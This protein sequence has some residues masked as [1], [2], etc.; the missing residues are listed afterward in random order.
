MARGRTRAR[1]RSIGVRAAVDHGNV[2]IHGGVLF[3]QLGVVPFEDGCG[4][5]C[6]AVM[7][8]DGGGKAQV[9][10]AHEQDAVAGAE[11]DDGL[12]VLLLAVVLLLC[13]VLG[14]ALIF[15]LRAGSSSSSSSRPLGPFLVLQLSSFGHWRRIILLE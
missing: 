15:L 1:G 2:G 12:V 8:D 10:L 9:G 3:D 14:W 4:D 5:V 6:A 13:L 11:G 7:L